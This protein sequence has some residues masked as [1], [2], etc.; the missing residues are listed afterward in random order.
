MQLFSLVLIDMKSFPSLIDSSC[1]H[2]FDLEQP[3]NADTKKQ[4]SN[5]LTERMSTKNDNQNRNREVKPEKGK[6]EYGHQRPGQKRDAGKD[7]QR[8][9]V[10]VV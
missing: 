1:H 6:K 5:K 8:R 10:Y 9:G 4:D 7:I 2:E 3:P